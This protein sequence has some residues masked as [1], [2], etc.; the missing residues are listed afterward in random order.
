MDRSVSAGGPRGRCAA[1][2]LSVRVCLEKRLQQFLVHQNFP[3]LESIAM[4]DLRSRGLSEVDTARVHAACASA[5]LLEQRAFPCPS[6][7]CPP[8]SPALSFTSDLSAGPSSPSIPSVSSVLLDLHS[9]LCITTA[10]RLLGFDGEK[11]KRQRCLCDSFCGSPHA[12]EESR[13]GSEAFSQ[14]RKRRKATSG[15]IWLGENQKRNKGRYR[16]LECTRLEKKPCES[17][18]RGVYCSVV[19]RGWWKSQASGLTEVLG[20]R[21]WHAGEMLE[22]FGPGG[23]LALTEVLLSCVVDALLACPCSFVVWLSFRG[24]LPLE[25]LQKLLRAALRKRSPAYRSEAERQDGYPANCRCS[26][27]PSENTSPCSQLQ[28]QDPEEETIL[29][30]L[31]QRVRVARCFSLKNL[32][33]AL[34]SELTC[35]A[36][37]Y[38]PS[39]ACEELGSSSRLYSVEDSSALAE[40]IEERQKGD[41]GTVKRR[42]TPESSGGDDRVRDGSAV[43]KGTVEADSRSEEANT[44]QASAERIRKHRPFSREHEVLPKKRSCRAQEGGERGQDADGG[45]GEVCSRVRGTHLA[46]VALDGLSLALL[47]HAVLDGHHLLQQVWI[48]LR[49]F[50]STTS[51]LLLVTNHIVAGRDPSNSTKLRC[52]SSDASALADIKGLSVSLPPPLLARAALGSA[53]GRCAAHVQLQ[54]EVLGTAAQ[55]SGPASAEEALAK[56]TGCRSREN[57]DNVRY[58]H[59][60]RVTVVK[61]PR[62]AAGLY[63]HVWVTPEGIHDRLSPA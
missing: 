35:L 48:R 7:L 2:H 34:D 45:E 38:S 25:R 24:T 42:I 49:Q 28:Q 54:V 23:G 39:P 22:V 6:W 26:S 57:T 11:E 36:A 20:G 12:D 33:N 1:P 19:N 63:V 59:L 17:G 15:E 62:Q 61:S 44:D 4:T 51:A 40:S 56:E 47:P 55:E 8:S 5:L 41:H 50:A 29:A 52:S 13:C 46:V 14:E 31:L 37:R 58:G 27:S 21:G 30:T 18:R 43:D 32:E 53:W 9:P 10:S 60:T 3:N 16:P